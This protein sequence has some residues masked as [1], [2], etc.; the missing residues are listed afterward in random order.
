MRLKMRF[1]F[2]VVTFRDFSRIITAHPSRLLR[3]LFGNARSRF[4][5]PSRSLEATSKKPRSKSEGSAVMVRSIYDACLKF[6]EEKIATYRKNTILVLPHLFSL[7]IEKIESLMS[8][9]VKVFL[10]IK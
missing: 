1:A 3:E 7:P 9:I 10:Y 5:N 4:G 8:V 2:W 6:F